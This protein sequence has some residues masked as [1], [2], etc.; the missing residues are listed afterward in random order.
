MPPSSPDS[1]ALFQHVAL[2]PLRHQTDDRLVGRTEFARRGLV[3][4]GQRTRRLDA[5]H[6]HAETDAE[7][8]HLAFTRELGRKYLAFRSALAEAT[9]HQDAVDLFQ[10]GRRVFLF[11]DFA[12]DPVEL[13]AH[14]VGHAAMRQRLD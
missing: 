10:P 7:I 2:Q 13:D 14:T 1:P 8:G 11:E 6:L 3:D 9:G 4:A 12:F 5:R